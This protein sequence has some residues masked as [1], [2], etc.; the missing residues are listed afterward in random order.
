MKIRSILLLR[1]A[2][3]LTC[4]FILLALPSIK[5]HAQI[6][7]ESP[8]EASNKIASNEITRKFYTAAIVAKSSQDRFLWTILPGIKDITGKNRGYPDVG[9]TW[10]V[11][12][13]REEK[14]IDFIPQTSRIISFTTFGFW[15]E[16]VKINW[17]DYDY[18]KQIIE[19]DFKI[20]SGWVEKEIPYSVWQQFINYDYKNIMDSDYSLY[21]NNCNVFALRAMGKLALWYTNSEV[22]MPPISLNEQRTQLV[23]SNPNSLL[24]KLKKINPHG[25]VYRSKPG[26]RVF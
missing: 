13:E 25:H 2:S 19:G 3:T 11:L 23:I 24:N 1:S 18:T 15:P 9:H 20:L 17:Y 26:T 7:Q 21:E 10:I 16:G 6:P 4:F 5:S 14:I 8:L 22:T 12:L